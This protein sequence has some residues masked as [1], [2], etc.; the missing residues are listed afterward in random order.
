MNDFNR[1]APTECI[2]PFLKWA[3]G[4][5]QLRSVLRQWYPSEFTGYVEPFL[6]GGAVFFDLAA[7]GRLEGRSVTLADLNG[8][9]IGC[10]L[11]VRDQVEDVIQALADLEQ[12]HTQD[13][14]YYRVR[15]DFN[16]VRGPLLNGAGLVS[17]RYTPHL[18]AQFIYLNRTGFNGLFRLNAK[19]GFN[20]PMGRYQAL[21][22]DD[23][24]GLR[25]ASVHL[26]Q[27]KV[28]IMEADFEQALEGVQS[29]DF[30]Y[31]D[32]PY[33]PLSGTARFPTHTG[34]GFAEADQ[35]RLQHCAVSLAG[36]RCSVVLSN[37]TE[38]LLT[39]LYTADADV[40]EAGLH[41]YPIPARLSINAKATA[42]GPVAEYVVS[43]VPEGAASFAKT[44]I[45]LDC[46]MTPQVAQWIGC[47]PEFPND[48]VYFCLCGPHDF[49]SG[50]YPSWREARDTGPRGGAGQ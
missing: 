36:R 12:G 2:D 14:H 46:G 33:G 17:E 25:R 3:G 35:R 11:T 38:P 40:L 29:S 26:G 4:K 39:L 44:E 16:T 41:V 24:Q 32:P 20:V 43:N 21:T 23:A 45:C 31:C 13:G 7:Q 48:L 28:R 50:Y 10:Y 37:P 5:R 49:G 18:A 27:P 30:V 9:L 34:S 47:D 8:D 22:T 15:D 42:R 6:G 1:V 19:G